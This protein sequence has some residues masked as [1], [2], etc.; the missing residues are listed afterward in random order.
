MFAAGAPARVL[1]NGGTMSAPG[2]TPKLQVIIAPATTSCP[3]L[4]PGLRVDD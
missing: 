3:I 1:F 2:A 4:L